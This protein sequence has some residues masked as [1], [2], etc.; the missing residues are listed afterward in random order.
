MGILKFSEEKL[1]KVDTLNRVSGQNVYDCYQCGKCTSGCPSAD[2][3]DIVPSQTMKFLQ[4]GEVD[5][6]MESN[7][8]WVCLACL[9]C[10]VRC[11]K[12]IDIAAVMEAL[13]LMKL[14][15]NYDFIHPNK[16][17]QNDL[18]ELP[19]IALVSAFRKMTP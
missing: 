14:R 6:V 16:I 2:E 8:P 15:T 5:K 9:I 17:D 4:L 10:S 7:T 11:P 13:R 19:P 18:E 1:L 12:N 3:M